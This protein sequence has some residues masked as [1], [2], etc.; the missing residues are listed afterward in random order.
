MRVTHL[1]HSCLL[2][3]SADTRILIDPGNYTPGFEGVRDLS[4][5]LVTHQHPDHL[6]RDRLPSLLAANPDAE[7]HS[8]PETAALLREAGVDVGEL[9]A[10]TDLT[11][12]GVTVSPRGA[13][14]AFNHDAIPS[15]A[16][17]GV[18]LSS[19][20]EPT[21]FHPGD[22]YDADPGPV[23]V[24]AVP[25]NAPWTPVRDTI[26]FVQRIAPASIVPIHDALL[27]EAG[28]KMYLM[29]VGTYGGPDLRV[30]DLAASEPT[31]LR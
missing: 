1:G 25:L 7:L 8:D 12:G 9:A 18:L 28:R 23:D 30:H 15:V 11:I 2:V 27:S 4:A 14:H 21:L 10:G 26:A 13:R 17:C 6:D 22:A 29:H 3:E 24:L 5:V 16:N 20:G 31:S 19:P